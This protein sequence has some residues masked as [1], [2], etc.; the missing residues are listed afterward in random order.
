MYFRPIAGCEF[1]SFDFQ[2]IIGEYWKILGNIEEYCSEK[3]D[4]EVGVASFAQFI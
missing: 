2:L 4:E 3:V 1:I